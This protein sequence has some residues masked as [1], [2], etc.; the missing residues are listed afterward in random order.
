[1]ATKIRIPVKTIAQQLDAI[2]H[3]YPGFRVSAALGALRATGKLRPTARSEPYTVEIRYV[4]KES[5]DIRVLSP[6]LIENS[7][8]EAIP[9]TYP[10]KKL[11]LYHPLYGDFGFDDLLSETILPWAALWLYHYENWHMTGDWLGGGSHPI[12]K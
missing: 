8:G 6:A 10:G 4:L 11:C 1:M 9:H 2:K 5:P 12:S 7:K 3:R